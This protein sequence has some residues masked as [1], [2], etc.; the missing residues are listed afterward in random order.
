MIVG[1]VFVGGIK[2]GKL[3]KIAFAGIRSA[4]ASTIKLDSEA[5]AIIDEKKKALIRQMEVESVKIKINNKNVDAT[6]N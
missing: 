2:P 1:S 5:D 6:K 4:F 3:S